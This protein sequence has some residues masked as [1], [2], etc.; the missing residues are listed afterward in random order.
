MTKILTS[1]FINDHPLIWQPVAKADARQSRG[2]P[3]KLR[4]GLAD[5]LSACMAGIPQAVPEIP[6][7]GSTTD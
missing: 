5:G 6:T 1:R 4:N 3:T 7:A 2:Q